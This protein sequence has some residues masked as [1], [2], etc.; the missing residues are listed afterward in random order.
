MAVSSWQ[1]FVNGQTNDVFT[2]QRNI[3]VDSGTATSIFPSI[4]AHVMTF[5]ILMCYHID[6]DFCR[7]FMPL[8]H[9]IFGV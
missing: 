2:N 6:I 4:A 9:P 7:R 8:F 5:I 3:I 1:N